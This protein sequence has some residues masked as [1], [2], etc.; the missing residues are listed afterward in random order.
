MCVEL[1][2][3]KMLMFLAVDDAGDALPE[4]VEKYQDARRQDQIEIIRFRFDLLILGN[5]LAG[6]GAGYKKRAPRH[7]PPPVALGLDW[8]PRK[9][10]AASEIAI[11]QECLS[12][13]T[14]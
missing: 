11:A 3:E 5:F 12:A 2:G 14:T 1:A 13:S 10:S 8:Q 6:A 4:L 7:P 9:I